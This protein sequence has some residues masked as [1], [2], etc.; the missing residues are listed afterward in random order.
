MRKKPDTSLSKNKEDL[1]FGIVI[2]DLLVYEIL[3]RRRP[4]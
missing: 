1:K 4:V 3:F 2:D